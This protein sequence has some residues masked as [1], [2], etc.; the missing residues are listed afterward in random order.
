M[1]ELTAGSLHAG[2]L[3]AAEAS[4]LESST[5]LAEAQGAAA[6]AEADLQDLGDAYNALEQTNY[7]LEAQ[8][9]ELRSRALSAGITSGL[10]LA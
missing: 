6:K 7:Q 2:K 5:A 8:L 10:A 4:A 9:S 3:A 1:G